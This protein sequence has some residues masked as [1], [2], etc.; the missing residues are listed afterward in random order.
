M[1]PLKISNYVSKKKNP[2]KKTSLLKK[3][4][5]ISISDVLNA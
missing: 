2:I 4:S 3:K 5:N 1:H